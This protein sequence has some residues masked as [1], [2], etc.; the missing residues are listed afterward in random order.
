MPAAE[1]SQRARR[2]DVLVLGSGVKLGELRVGIHAV[3]TAEGRNRTAIEGRLVRQSV[4]RIH[5][6]VRSIQSLKGRKAGGKPHW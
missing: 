5:S 2:T 1:A 6:G 4:F 3:H